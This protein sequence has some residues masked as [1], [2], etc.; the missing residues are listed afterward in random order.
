MTHLHSFDLLTGAASALS[1]LAFPASVFLVLRRPGSLA[2]QLVTTVHRPRTMQLMGPSA[3]SQSD[4]DELLP[5]LDEDWESQA[6]DDMNA[7]GAWYALPGYRLALA[8]SGFKISM[9]QRGPSADAFILWNPAGRGL[10]V[11][12]DL[13]ELKQAGKRMAQYR[14]E[15]QHAP[16][17]VAWQRGFSE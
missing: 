16:M 1:A 13:D 5:F 10:F 17:P 15:F 6:R 11:G 3:S 12:P 9:E 7:S 8:N 14:N 2:M 4:S